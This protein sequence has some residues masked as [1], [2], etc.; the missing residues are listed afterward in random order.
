MAEIVSIGHRP[1][2][3]VEEFIGRAGIVSTANVA[4]RF[5]WTMRETLTRLNTMA[6]EKKIIKIGLRNS[7]RHATNEW[8]LP[9]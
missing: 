4:N 8:R 6:A 3:T 2:E 5:A 7:D 9:D 1:Q